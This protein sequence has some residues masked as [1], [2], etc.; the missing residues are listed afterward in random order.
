M[1]R[2][3]VLER[4]GNSTEINRDENG[5]IDGEKLI[6]STIH[7]YFPAQGENLFSIHYYITHTH[8]H[9]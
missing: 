8:N 7:L 1:L 2:E 5:K 9:K 6:Q 4:N 3:K